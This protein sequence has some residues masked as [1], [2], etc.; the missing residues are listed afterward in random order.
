MSKV[1]ISGKPV[2]DDEREY[3]RHRLV[4]DGGVCVMEKYVHPAF[5]LPPGTY[6]LIDVEAVRE[7]REFINETA[8]RLVVADER[9]PGDRFE[10][11]LAKLPEAKL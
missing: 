6:A 9:G 7:V 1:I 4:N 2:I 10:R 3:F 8:N 5:S 11:I